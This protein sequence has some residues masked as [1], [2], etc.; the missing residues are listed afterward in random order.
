MCRNLTVSG[1]VLGVILGVVLSVVF[2]SVLDAVLSLPDAIEPTPEGSSSPP[3]WQIQ[4]YVAWE[5]VAWEAAHEAAAQAEQ[6]SR[7]PGDRFPSLEAAEVAARA[8]AKSHRAESCAWMATAVRAQAAY[9]AMQSPNFLEEA[10]S[11]KK[12]SDYALFR[13]ILAENRADEYAAA[14]AREALR[15]DK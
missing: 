7:R 14:L 3:L 4:K 2:R 9:Q 15:S 1:V 11:A 12:L 13:A 8:A 10:A 5:A 6:V